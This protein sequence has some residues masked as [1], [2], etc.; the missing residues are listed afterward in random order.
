VR[1]DG[2]LQARIENG[3][4]EIEGLGAFRGDGDRTCRDVGLPVGHRT[5]LRGHVRDVQVPSRPL[6]ALGDL[7]PQIDGESGLEVVMGDDERRQ[8]VRGDGDF[9]GF[10][11]CR[12]QCP[13][14]R[15]KQDD[16]KQH[17]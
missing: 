2:D 12:G 11:R 6:L 3:L 9:P 10:G 15:H 1:R 16:D 5:Q 17:P 4:R 8:V 7:L 13:A 14:E